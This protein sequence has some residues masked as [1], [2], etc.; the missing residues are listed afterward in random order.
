[1]GFFSNGHVKME[2]IVDR[3][4]YAPGSITSIQTRQDQ[5][6]EEELSSEGRH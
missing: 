2:A 5:V 1:M 4:A 6:L 3:R